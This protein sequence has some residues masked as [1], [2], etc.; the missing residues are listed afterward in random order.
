MFEYISIGLAILAGI[1]AAVA[2]IYRKGK[3]DGTHTATDKS[4]KDDI[5]DLCDK[6]DN[7]AKSNDK[8][9]SQLFSNVKE[10]GT[11]IDKL[12]GSS[13]IIND[14]ITRHISKSN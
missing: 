5:K 14:L 3:S 12:Q 4:L 9:H 11:K 13:D 2:Y 7:N 10:I 8:V 6:V 1:F